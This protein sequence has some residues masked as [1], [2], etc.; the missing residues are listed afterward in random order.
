MLG[1]SKAQDVC[2]PAANKPSTQDPTAGVTRG[3]AVPALCEMEMRLAAH[4]AVCGGRADEHRKSIE[5][6]HGIPWS[7]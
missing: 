6:S 5:I 4:N 2:I 7:A 1:V 3:Y